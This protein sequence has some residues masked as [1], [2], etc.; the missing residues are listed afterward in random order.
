MV[1]AL[2]VLGLLLIFSSSIAGDLKK[3]MRA[4][5]K[6]DWPKTEEIIKKVLESEPINPGVRYY[7]SLLYGNEEFAN[8]NMDS[9]RVQIRQAIEDY[10]TAS[11][12]KL[13]EMVKEGLA[14]S[15]LYDQLIDITDAFYEDSRQQMSL[16]VW[17]QFI[18]RFPDAP[19]I[20]NAIDTRDS[21]ALENAK[22][23]GSIE[24]WKQFL[25]TYPNSKYRD[26][27][28]TK[29]DSL[30][31]SGYIKNHNE[32]QLRNYVQANKGN[33][34]ADMALEHLL[35]LW[36]KSGSLSSFVAFMDEFEKDNIATVAADWL[37]H[38]DK[39]Q[40][41][42][43]FEA[44][45][46]INS[47]SINSAKEWGDAFFFPVY[48]D[49]YSLVSATKDNKKLTLSSL[50][51]DIICN[52]WTTDVIAGN[53]D[54]DAV[55]L[56]R[57]GSTII[58]GHLLT[59]LGYGLMFVDQDGSKSIYHKTGRLIAK[60]IDDAEIIQGKVLKVKKNNWGLLSLMGLPLAEYRFDD[61]FV[62]GNF[63]FFQKDDLIAT[64]TFQQIIDSFPEGLFLEFKFDDYELISSDELIGFRDDRECLLKSDGSFR[65]PWGRHQI[66]PSDSLGYVH[67]DKGYSLYGQEGNQYYPY[68]EANA[69]FVLSKTNEGNWTLY[70][71]QLKWAKVYQDSIRL[72]NPYFAMSV[73]AER[74][75][76]FHNQL[77]FVL[78]PTQSPLVF[79]PK[80]N[81][82]LLRDKVSQVIN[83]EGKV[84]FSG[85]FEEIRLVSDT[86]F[87]ISFREKHGLISA[88]GKE[89]LPIKFEYID[90]NDGMI[91]ILQNGK[92]GALDLVSNVRFEPTLESKPERIG[93]YYKV[94][95]YGKYGM[96]DSSQKEVVPF[97]YDQL[98]MWTTNQVW[99]KSGER[100]SLFDVETQNSLMDVTLLSSLTE[101][102]EYYK[103]YGQSGFG[104]IH[105]DLG[106]IVPPNFTDV[107]LMGTSELGVLMA[108]QALTEAGFYVLTY[109]TLKGEKIYSHAYRRDDYERVFCDD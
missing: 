94:A 5:E 43:E 69:G 51:T 81:H 77:E 36:T 83:S 14:S 62:D 47:D 1:R 78:K 50:S 101:N 76:F 55:I 93:R 45:N 21:L 6:G 89:V 92:I 32:S 2:S 109:Y 17:E 100:F 34:I 61:I 8:S 22:S 91:S 71:N 23:I 63:W 60:D 106:V 80:S 41:F 74:K 108:E 70:S 54:G 16:T 49:G 53:K 39:E 66:Y 48:E 95:K 57:D 11:V 72:L 58:Q 87:S 29:R 10:E 85:N 7:Y 33:V 84:V 102:D 24:A 40:G 96:L 9:A 25:T 30:M 59:D 26:M 103:F 19:Q 79:S 90:S 44:Y 86:L 105:R 35:K 107:R 88:S 75:L 65:V 12:D 64:A 20:S 3:V 97:S 15:R 38:I 31:V 4:Y 27:V 42:K 73:G 52:G 99:L 82:I 56:S 28:T 98:N 13:E 37:F 18:V 104:I 46:Q 67:D 68:M